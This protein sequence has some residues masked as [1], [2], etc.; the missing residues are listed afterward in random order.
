MTDQPGQKK[1]KED[2]VNAMAATTR[3]VAA[4]RELE[5]TFT[6]DVSGI[7]ENQIRLAHLPHKPT[8]KDIAE[9]RGQADAFALK[10]LYHDGKLHRK[11]APGGTLARDIYDAVEE[12][13]VEAIG[14]RQMQG[15]RGNLRSLVEKRV[16]E[17]G[18]NRTNDEEH[19]HLATIL[20]LMV[21]ERLTGENAPDS[22]LSAVEGQRRCVYLI[23]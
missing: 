17:T 13:R 2:F 15:I 11:L 14:A 22:A 12:A 20:G 6:A 4:D 3:A 10:K 8:K 1:H 5:V 19:S 23:T 9:L 7:S 21:R 16:L 18:I